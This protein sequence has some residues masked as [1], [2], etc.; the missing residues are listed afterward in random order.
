MLQTVYIKVSL[1]LYWTDERLIGREAAHPG[2]PLPESLWGPWPELANAV[3]DGMSVALLA[4]VRAPKAQ[5]A[6]STPAPCRLLRD[7]S[8]A[9]AFSH[10]RLRETLRETAGRLWRR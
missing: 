8:V 3:S 5:Y 1:N 9:R 2:A 10:E 4:K 7:R 6:T